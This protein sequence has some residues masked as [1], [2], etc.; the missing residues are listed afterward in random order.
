MKWFF[1]IFFN[2][3]ALVSAQKLI[4]SDAVQD[5]IVKQL[6]AFP[7]E[8]IHIHTDRTMYVPGEKIWFKAY[9]VDAVLHQ[10]PTFSQYAYIE[11]I[12]SSDSLVHRVMVCGD[13]YGLFHGY[14]FLSE[15]IPE[16]D[17]T[18]RAYTR[19][20]ENLGDDYFFKKHIR[21]GNIEAVEKRAQRQPRANYDVSFFPEGG[22][23]PEGIFS[24]VAFKA[25][26]Q[27]GASE[28]ITG[29]I[30]DNEGNHIRGVTTVFAG[31]GSF[32]FKPE[33]G[34]EYFLISKNSDGQE[35]R[36][37][38]PPAKKTCTISA[39]YR[40]KRHY[41]QLKKS[42]DL[43]EKPLYLL[44]HCRG[45]VLHF[46]L[47]NHHNEYVSFTSD[48]LPSGV[49]QAILFDEYKNPLSERLIFNRN[50]DQAILTFLSDK[51][52]YQKRERV[53]IDIRVTNPEGNPLASH[54]SVAITDDKDIAIDSLHTIAS[55]LL[56]SS[57][58]RGYIESPGYYLQDHVEAELARDH[59]MM[60]HG[61]RRYDIPEAVKGNYK[62]PATGFEVAKEISG[63]VKSLSLGRPVANGEVLFLSSDGNIV[64]TET[65]SAGHFR[66]DLHYPDS[67]NL[68]ISAKNQKGNDRVELVLNQEKFPILKH[69]AF[70]ELLSSTSLDKAD[71]TS[72]F[73]KKAEQRAKYDE[74]MRFIQLKEVTV[75]AHRIEK[76][77]EARLKFWYNDGSD[78]TIY[79]EQIEKRFAPHV[80]DLLLWFFPRFVSS[81]RGTGNPLI[82]IDG[83]YSY[84]LDELSWVNVQDIESIDVFK[85][86]S[87]SAAIF[88][89]RGGSGVISITT[90]REAPLDSS[91]DFSANCAS[92]NPLGFQKPVEFYAP[93][94]DTPESKNFIV[95][96]YRTTIYWKPDMIIPDDGKA[97]F[98][99]YTSDFPATY[100]VVIEGLTKDGKIIRQVETIT[101]V[102]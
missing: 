37:K 94:Y 43:P 73:I 72:D 32:V 79:R 28:F 63:I 76:K 2:S 69:A 30:V 100:S 46:A 9:I 5:S 70:N 92:I 55:S 13:E 91:G 67:T 11:L 51:P 53:S 78:V 58:L 36:F 39:Y 26:N 15:L 65:D 24:R 27:R 52:F 31:M 90:R 82:I 6:A 16:G 74:D 66:F 84:G 17:Y 71:V 75:T 89:S 54:V 41:I 34:K 40:N 48:R 87:P 8:K 101:I 56:L 29:V 97:S 62:L 85:T 22:N 23:L 57:E 18:L 64:I 14:I 38:L 93:K 49:I 86:T 96:D 77:D 4:T 20:M 95:P 47:W 61:W 44:V 35:K 59:L 42:P 33:E 3:I 12:D 25:L 50:D 88:G 19:Y 7:Q 10:S 21:I 98:E 60:M 68:F 80:T 83:V 1:I 99:F 81:I 102:Q 45:E